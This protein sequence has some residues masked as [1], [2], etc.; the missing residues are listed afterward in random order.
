MRICAMMPPN[1]E[2]GCTD[3]ARLMPCSSEGRMFPKQVAL[4]YLNA[5][6]YHGYISKTPNGKKFYRAR[7]SIEAPEY[8]D[9]EDGE[10]IA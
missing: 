8:D 9:Y 3:V 1:K 5:L 7:T 4:R 10:D 2:F 6:A